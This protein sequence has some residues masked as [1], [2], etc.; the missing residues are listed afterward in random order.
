MDRRPVSRARSSDERFFRSGETFL[1]DLLG[2]TVGLANGGAIQTSYGYDPYGV[3]QVVG[4]ASDNS[5]QY[6]GRENDGTALLSYRNRYYSP[7]WGRFITE[8][9]IGLDGGDSNLYRYV[10]NS[11]ISFNDPTGL[12]RGG[13]DGGLNQITTPSKPTPVQV[14]I[15]CG[16]F[17]A[18]N[19]QARILR[20]FPGQF[21]EQEVDDVLRAA[22]QGD[23]AA[24]TARKLLIDG[25]FRK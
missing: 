24:Q 16:E 3:T 7:S 25:R 20:I 11:P 12:S 15:T 17:I 19:C 8:D 6:S 18:A 23:A 2:S 9:P 1:T 14:A 4:S 5:F 22:R 13:T 10:A 21:L